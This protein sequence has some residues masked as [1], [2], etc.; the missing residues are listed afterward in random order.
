M[1]KGVPGGFFNRYY[2]GLHLH[3]CFRDLGAVGHMEEIRHPLQGALE[4][5]R[6]NLACI[7]KDNVI[8]ELLASCGELG[9]HTALPMGSPPSR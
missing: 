9:R 8:G 3:D 1:R 6:V 4:I 2:D 7:V 5:R